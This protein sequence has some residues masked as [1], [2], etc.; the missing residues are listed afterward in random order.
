MLAIT[1]KSPSPQESELIA[2]TIADVLPEAISNIVEGSS[3]KLVENG[4]LPVKKASPN[5]MNYT[6]AGLLIFG[7][8]SCLMIALKVIMDTKI[9][10]QSYI[11]ENYPEIQ[12]LS[13]VPDITK[14][15]GSHGKY[16]GY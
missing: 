9:R 8:I 6:L 3:V 4:V 11:I 16:G 7:F 10:S 14:D 2:N 1:V 12:L 15:D 13:T 5:V